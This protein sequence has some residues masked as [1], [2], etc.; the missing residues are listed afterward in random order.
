MPFKGAR[1]AP[2]LVRIALLGA[3]GTGKT[4]LAQELATALQSR[5]HKARLLNPFE[6]SF[7]DDEFVIADDTALLEAVQREIERHDKS[8]YLDTIT[9]QG[10]FDLTLLTGLDLPK[11][12]SD[13]QRRA[14]AR[15]R[16]ILQTHGLRYSVVYGS[17]EQ[18]L[19]CALAAVDHC[20]KADSHVPAEA[21][22]RWQWVCDKCSDAQC[23][24]QMFSA[25]L[26]QERTQA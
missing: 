3:S 1:Y 19:A 6:P 15:L 7:F 22:A 21:Q 13:L 2:A 23:E 11:A 18:R 8:L 5:G 26:S 17:G 14:D 20:N 25:L 16:E 10:T 24:H 4:W 9:A 12:H